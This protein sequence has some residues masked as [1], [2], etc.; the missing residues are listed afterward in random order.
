MPETANI[1][2]T[3]VARLE[4]GLEAGPAGGKRR[5]IGNDGTVLYNLLPKPSGHKYFEISFRTLPFAFGFCT[6]FSQQFLR[7]PPCWMEVPMFLSCPRNVFYILSSLH[8]HASKARGPAARSK[9][10]WYESYPTEGLSFNAHT[11]A[12]THTKT[13][14][15]IS[16]RLSG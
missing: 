7:P 1:K 10:L 3:N 8:K 4:R 11:N 13:P 14:P 15:T 2:S 12:H 9:K 6:P 16:A 5:R